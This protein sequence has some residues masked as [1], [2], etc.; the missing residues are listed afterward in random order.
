[1]INVVQMK[2][3]VIVMVAMIKKTMTAVPA[4]Y[5]IHLNRVL[6]VLVLV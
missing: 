5:A 3:A 2:E 4:V 1:M 6:A